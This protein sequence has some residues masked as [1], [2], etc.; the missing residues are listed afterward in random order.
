MNHL[1]NISDE[2]DRLPFSDE[3]LNFDSADV[4]VSAFVLVQ[5]TIPNASKLLQGGQIALSVGDN[6]VNGHFFTAQHF[7]HGH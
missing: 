1:V 3:K 5:S 4:N 7:S 2:G 6:F